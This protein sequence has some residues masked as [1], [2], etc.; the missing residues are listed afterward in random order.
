MGGRPCWALTDCPV[1]CLPLTLWQSS[2]D[3]AGGRPAQRPGSGGRAG[4]RRQ[5]P[6]TPQSSCASGPAPHDSH[7]L[8]IGVLECVV[9]CRSWASGGFGSR[10]ASSSPSCSGSG[11]S[12]TP[13]CTPPSY[14]SQSQVPSPPFSLKRETCSYEGL[15]RFHLKE[16]LARVS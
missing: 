15:A 9:V 3:G 5:G 14:S 4:P 2:A 12:S 10:R 13:P 7:T 8:T 6:A 16:R 1:P 11:S